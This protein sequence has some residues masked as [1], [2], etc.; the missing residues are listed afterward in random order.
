MTRC[1]YSH[2][3]VRRLEKAALDVELLDDEGL[4]GVGVAEDPRMRRM[5]LDGEGRERSEGVD[6][7]LL[8]FVVEPKLVSK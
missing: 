2:Q 7:D 4:V 1:R 5:R 3:V 6:L 8:T